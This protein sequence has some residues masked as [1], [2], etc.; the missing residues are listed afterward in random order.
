MLKTEVIDLETYSAV[1][2]VISGYRADDII[3]TA[4]AVDEIRAR[5]P[6]CRCDDEELVGLMVH[7]MSGKKIAVSFDHR[8][9]ASPSELRNAVPPLWQWQTAMTCRGRL[10]H[11]KSTTAS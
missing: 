1:Y 4:F 10:K 3:S 11:D 6:E 9:A 2:A 7:A 5:F 8:V